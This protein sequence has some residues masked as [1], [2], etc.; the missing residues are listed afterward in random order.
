MSK[1]AL[2]THHKQARLDFARKYMSYGEKWKNVIF[3]DEKKFNLDG[4]DGYSA[5]SH[6]LRHNDP[7]RLSRNFGA[8]SLMTWAAFSAS[9]KTPICFVGTKMNSTDYTNFLDEVLITFMDKTMNGQGIYQ[10]D[11]AAIHV[12]R[13]S[14]AWFLDKDIELLG[15]P[16]CSPDL[17]PVE[18]LWGILS[19][20]VYRNGKQYSSISEF[21][22]AIQNCWREIQN[23]TLKTLID[24]MPNRIFA[25]INK[26]GGATKY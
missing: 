13:Q 11:N 3:S 7:P 14:K 12:S 19:R 1:P 15:W 26:N 5:Y 10:Q 20:A 9:G 2:K 8:G 21:K 17:N 6:D 16:A 4:P 18:N 24:S 23:D 22:M 25:V